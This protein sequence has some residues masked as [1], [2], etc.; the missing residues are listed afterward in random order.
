[1]C[2]TIEKVL[3]RTGLPADRLEL[4]ITE[5]VLIAD[6]ARGLDMLQRIRATGV[7]IVMD[8]FGTGYSSLSYFRE[9]PFDK[10]KID[11]SFIKDMLHDNHARAI[12]EAIISLGRGLNLKVV[13]EGVETAEQLAE[14]Q[15][16]GCGQAQ[17]FYISHPLP[18]SQFE[19]SILCMPGE[20]EVA[21]RSA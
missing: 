21:A 19:G 8:D 12:V 2:A 20:K 1:M 18:I 5:A 13:A 4:E 10:V 3:R 17:G 7:Q 6:P 15:S 9:F 16:Q 11:Q 14:L